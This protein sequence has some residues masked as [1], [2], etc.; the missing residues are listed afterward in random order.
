[1]TPPKR[2]FL[3]PPHMSG[4][5]RGLIEEVF[6]TNYVAPAGPMIER[7]ES[8]FCEATGFAHAA[9]ISSGTAAI[10]LAL[11][12][13]G[14]RPGDEVWTPTLTF[15]GGV[16]PIA[17]LGAKPVFFD[18]APESWTLDVALLA[19]EMS[20]AARAGKLPAAVISVDLY[21]QC[22]DLD[23]IRA[24]CGP[25]GVPVIADAAE[26][27]GATYKGRHAGKGATA[28]AFSFNGNKII[29]TGGGGMIASDD[30]NLVAQARYLSQ[31]AR[32]AVIH[33]EH[34]TIGYNYR[35]SG[36]N[37]AVGVGQLAVLG[38]RV[39]RRREIFARYERELGNLPGFSFMPEA[40]TGTTNR[41]LTVMLIDPDKT[42]T[43]PEKLRLVLEAQNIESRPVWKPMHMQPIFAGARKV[44]GKV[45]E[46]L[47]ATG[48]CLPSGTQMSEEDQGR[49]ISLVHEECAGRQG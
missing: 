26:A 6:D 29:T 48:L 16:S 31:Q 25:H 42:H 15:I 20:R 41:W 18:V 8:A 11:R 27:M 32:E 40:S 43:T 28:A 14:V 23:A 33:Y 35:M 24:V 30:A 49:V 39:A 10:H 19:D 45:S 3:S 22:A 44:G 37:A 5:E 1:M 46:H 13:A 38:E 4:T 2:I 21:G 9:A 7:F 12:L 36:L 47:F 17:Y 34:T